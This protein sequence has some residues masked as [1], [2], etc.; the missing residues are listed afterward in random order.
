MT[1]GEILKEYINF[2]RTSIKSEGKIKDVERYIKS[3]LDSSKIKL[4]NFKEKELINFLNSISKHYSIPTL[5]TIKPI[6]KHFLKWKFEDYSARFR[7]LDRLCRI[8]KAE[9]TYKPEQMLTEKE[10]IKLANGE[11]DL[12]WKV[13]WLVYFFG[14]FRPSEVAR[15]KFG[16]INFEK[17]GSAIIKVYL[18][19]NKKDV[20]KAIPKPVTDCLKKWMEHTPT[21][22]E[23]YLFPSSLRKGEHMKAKTGYFRLVKLSK[24]ILGRKV[25]PYCIRHSFG[26]IKYNDDSLSKDHVAEQ[27]GHS[28]DMES[29]Y[30][31]L[32]D[33]QKIINAK[34]V[35]AKKDDLTPE[36]KNRIKELEKKIETLWKEKRETAKALV[37][38]ANSVSDLKRKI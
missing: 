28:K 20:Y 26:S 30:K 12:M 17:D 9:Q 15:L 24:R 13:W 7:N 25:V 23:D 16:N 31:N 35:W 2:K 32:N 8:E 29:V 4:E 10:I 11:T 21:D 5:N 6:L 36:E 37:Q 33:D 19:K 22:K 1:K 38:L 14:A 3:F 34:K 27:M 18:P